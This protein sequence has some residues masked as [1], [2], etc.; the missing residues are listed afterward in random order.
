MELARQEVNMRKP[1][2]YGEMQY[3][4]L[5]RR[6]N[7]PPQ[8][9]PPKPAVFDQLQLQ[10][11]VTGPLDATLAMMELCEEDQ[12]E[13]FTHYPKCKSL[14]MRKWEKVSDNVLRCISF[15]MAET[16]EEI[17]LSFS[18]VKTTHLEI[19]LP[20]MRKLRVV[21][22]SGCPHVN[23]ACMNIL[24]R[25]CAANIEELLADQC[26]QFTV[27]P[28]LWLSGSIGFNSP[29]LSR[30]SILDLSLCPLED[31]GLL[32]VA[33]CCKLLR[34]F[35]VNE[36]G[37]LTD[38]S[39]VPL[40][41]GNPELRLVSLR[42]VRSITN[43]VLAALG[44]TCHDLVSLNLFK[45]EN[46]S[47]KGL[48]ALGKGCPRLQC[49]NL[50][51]L[52]KLDEAPLV[53]ITNNC[54]GLNMLNVTG[55]SAITVNGL[56]S[57]IQ[58]MSQV[59][60]ARSFVGF[61]P[62]DGFV[63][64]RLESHLSMV[65]ENALDHIKKEKKKDR[66]KR[67]MKEKYLQDVTI[68][69][70]NSIK[71]YMYRYKLR[72]DFYRM[73][74]DR[75]AREG[76]LLIQRVARGIQGR[77]RYRVKW[78]EWQH[79][80]SHAPQAVCIQRWVRGHHD[81]VHTPFVSQAMR[82]MYNY[83]AK[84]AE[85]IVAVRFQANARRFLAYKRVEAW[86]EVCGRRDQD[87]ASSILIMQMLARR[88]N[89]YKELLRRRFAKLRKEKLEDRASRKLQAWYQKQLNRYLSKLSG[90]ELQ[91]AM[92]KTWKMTLLLQRSY[93]GF[94]G[95]ER[96]NKMRIEKAMYNFAAT[97]IQKFFRGAR[98]LYWRDMR[99]NVIAAY[100]LDRQYIER[101]ESVAASRL[102]YK[103]YVI[104]NQ[105]DSASASE[106]PEDPD[107]DVEWVLKHDKK[108][109]KPYWINPVTQIITY[110]EPLKPFHKEITLIGFRVRVF[111]TAQ[112]IWYEG[113]ITDFHKRKRRHRIEYDD[114]DHEWLN[115]EHESERVQ[116]QEHDG[117]WIMV[118]MHKAPG[119]LH[120]ADKINNAQ[121][122]AR[123]K[124]DAMDDANQ[125]KIIHNDE[126]KE[127]VI[128]ISTKNGE[129]RAGTIDSEHWVV[130][131]DEFGYPCFFHVETEE[132]VYEDPRFIHDTDE[133]L[134]QQREYVSCSMFFL[135]FRVCDVRLSLF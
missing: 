128:Y 26:P 54:K 39:L 15:T 125:W 134:N 67:E 31:K 81:R 106:D 2:N 79:F 80:L 77:A 93:R 104:E 89:A 78:D 86:R 88:Y 30:I 22:V 66:L 65:K 36:C 131:E 58:G 108:M 87:E 57:L 99:L 109:D 124:I 6:E 48:A 16:L 84:E 122:E 83:R 43:K 101:R 52:N 69:A 33:T 47:N 23:G 59:E 74:Q 71:Q 82:D 29:K 129:I 91:K 111:W 73:W 102:R 127:A 5:K 7:E 50:S 51:G 18:H 25:L 53:T 130:H 1:K 49:L 9:R 70:A 72:Q 46:I 62:V 37:L 116:I 14:M 119:E 11:T 107:A 61:K 117:S 42:N 97:M 132:V 113:V 121:Q 17:D 40:V 10:P 85:A 32:A 68:Q 38:A 28:L 34:F 24:A 103:A 3:R 96:V 92:N 63:E 120:E 105:R 12:C 20:R 8:E 95:R 133:D 75:R 126:Q 118:L 60:L 123:F 19:I 94:K 115:I 4:N 98:I 41:C 56:N 112:E 90:A 55:I 21:K 114:G 110:D 135:P 44:A 27:E 64:K 35:N 45:C 76:C 100:A 13:F